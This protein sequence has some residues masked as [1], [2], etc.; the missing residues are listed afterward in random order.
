MRWYQ[1]QMLHVLFCKQWNGGRPL[2]THGCGLWCWWWWSWGS[3]VGQNARGCLRR[4]IM[5]GK[6]Q[7]LYCS[8]GQ[9]FTWPFIC[10]CFNLSPCFCS[11]YQQNLT[12][13]GS[14]FQPGQQMRTRGTRALT[15]HTSQLLRGNF[16]H[17][18][19]QGVEVIFRYFFTSV[20]VWCKPVCIG[21]K[22]SLSFSFSLSHFPSF[23]L[24][25]EF[26]SNF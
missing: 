26:G 24:H 12:G 4:K 18:V 25:A 6:H 20:V 11:R 19:F 13:Q 9:L 23:S 21:N 8:L 7:W 22:F 2:E 17:L 14:A 10:W 5:A 1:Q 16:L 15:N 3:S